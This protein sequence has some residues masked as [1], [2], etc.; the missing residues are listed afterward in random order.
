MAK[1]IDDALAL[2]AAGKS[3]RECE[4]LTGIPATTITRKAKERG[5][6]KGSVVQLV[7]DM[8][9]VSAEFGAQN[10]AVQEVIKKEVSKQLEGMAF[11]AS[12]A[13]ETV[14]IGF[15]S[16]E[17]DPNPLGMK[18]ILDGMKSAMQVEGIVPFYPQPATTNINNSS[19]AQAAVIRQPANINF[20]GGQRSSN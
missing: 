18:T 4:K 8:A 6:I 19:N 14:E 9:R 13:R 3:P 5:V 7:Q 20:K 10:G 15:K 2:L 11:Y 1:T 16:F 17:M 12:K